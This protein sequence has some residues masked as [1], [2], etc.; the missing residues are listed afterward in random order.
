M[1]NFDHPILQM[2]FLIRGGGG[3]FQSGFL[4]IEIKER[5]HF[6]VEARN[7]GHSYDVTETRKTSA[8]EILPLYQCEV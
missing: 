3:K 6:A 7:G 1:T 5:R 2:D 4:D 8:R